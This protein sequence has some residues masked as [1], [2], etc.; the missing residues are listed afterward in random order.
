[1]DIPNNRLHFPN[2]KTVVKPPRTIPSYRLYREI[3]GESGDFWL[4]CETVPARTRLHDWEISIHRHDGLFQL[5]SLTAGS[6]EML[7]REGPPQPLEAPCAVFVP[8]RAAHGF[9]F[10]RDID[11]LVVTALADR[12]ASLVEADPSIAVHLAE[13]RITPLP[14]RDPAARGLRRAVGRIHGE[15]AVGGPGGAL[16]LEAL[17]TDALVSLARAGAREAGS[18]DGASDRDRR[19]MALLETLI[20]AHFREQR[21]VAF[22]AERIG[23][24]AAHL[25]RIARALAGE[26]VQGLIALRVMTAAR[27]DLIFTPTPVQAIALSLGF[28]DPA[29]FNRYFRR[30]AGVTP[31]AFRAA[32]RGMLSP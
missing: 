6:G 24:S 13:P 30:H 26:S 25:N 4:H 2:M 14:A 3:T 16:L 18:G 9:R 10:S 12:L 22:Y 8:P 5:F 28:A 19:R 11:G 7:G 27:R 31:G 29:Y 17:M 32:E 21:P 1:M 15:L 20:G 23:V